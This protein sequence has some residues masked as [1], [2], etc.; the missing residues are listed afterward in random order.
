MPLFCSRVGVAATHAMR[1]HLRVCKKCRDADRA[2]VQ[3]SYTMVNTRMMS[4]R[5]FAQCNITI[6][7]SVPEDD[8]DGVFKYGLK[9]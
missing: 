3:Y 1:L 9:E 7:A 2:D 5:D 8:S 4:T 6:K